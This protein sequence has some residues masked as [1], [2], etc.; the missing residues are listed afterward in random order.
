MAA[1]A[2]ATLVAS[3]WRLVQI[4]ASWSIVV[5]VVKEATLISNTHE[6]ETLLKLLNT[7]LVK[8]IQSVASVHLQL[9]L[10]HLFGFFYLHGIELHLVAVPAACIVVASCP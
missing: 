4:P 3:G 7:I 10:S 5:N 9:A 8:G 1:S 6:L 2:A